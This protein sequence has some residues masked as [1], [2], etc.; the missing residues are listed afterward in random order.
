MI[1]KNSQG[2]KVDEYSYQPENVK[3]TYALY[4]SS[5]EFFSFRFILLKAGEP[6]AQSGVLIHY[7]LFLLTFPSPTSLS[8][9]NNCRGEGWGKFKHLGNLLLWSM[10]FLSFL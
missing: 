7:S 4:I 2:A 1:K 10:S 6:V 3:K 9:I 8:E 5:I